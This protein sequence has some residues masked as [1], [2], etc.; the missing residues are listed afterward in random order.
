M[1]AQL[2]G[3]EEGRGTKSSRSELCSRQVPGVEGQPKEKE[4]GKGYGCVRPQ[5]CRPQPGKGTLVWS[6]SSPT[7]W[8]LSSFEEF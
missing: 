8:F 4:E 3:A 6:V 2:F 7:G 5:N 1:G